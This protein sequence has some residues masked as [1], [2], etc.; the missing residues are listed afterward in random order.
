MA[1]LLSKNMRC[2]PFGS[3]RW[4]WPQPQPAFTQ[5][6]CSKRMWRVRLCAVAIPELERVLTVPDLVAAI[7]DVLLH[8]GAAALVGQGRVVDFPEPAALDQAVAGIRPELDAI[9]EADGLSIGLVNW[10]PPPM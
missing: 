2:R 8:V 3:G 4:A 6:L 1:E 5:V 9:A 10:W 7:G